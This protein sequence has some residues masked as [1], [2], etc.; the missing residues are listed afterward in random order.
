M[1]N[2]Y[3]SMND[4]V[5]AT[6][7]EK[8][9]KAIEMAPSLT[10]FDS[11][12]YTLGGK[13]DKQAGP[14]AQAWRY[15]L[16]VPIGTTGSTTEWGNSIDLQ[17]FYMRDNANATPTDV[18]TFTDHFSSSHYVYFAGDIDIQPLC[19]VLDGSAAYYLIPIAFVEKL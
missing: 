4:S 9:F 17:T 5:G 16:F 19:T 3:I 13:V 6:T 14:T 7:S 12:D 18:V 15:T 2:N 8:K 10:R 11:I 1:A